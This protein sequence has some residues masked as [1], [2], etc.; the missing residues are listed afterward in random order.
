M[1]TKHKKSSARKGE[2]AI[3]NI[4]LEIMDRR[5]EEVYYQYVIL[6]KMDPQYFMDWVESM[7]LDQLLM[8]LQIQIDC[9][10]FFQE[11]DP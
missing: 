10:D 9:G 11:D 6:G 8:F 5:L 7:D 3:Q 2:L 1:T 4:L